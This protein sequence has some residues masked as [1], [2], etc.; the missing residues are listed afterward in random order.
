VDNVGEIASIVED[1]VQGLAAGE[2]GNGLLNTPGVF[3]LSLALP[4]EDGDTSRSDAKNSSMSFDVMD[5]DVA[6]DVRGGGVVLGG[7]DVL[8]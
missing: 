8:E 4:C 5:F 1:H 6:S 3:L 7:E 2:A